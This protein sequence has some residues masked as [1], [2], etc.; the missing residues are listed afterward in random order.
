[1]W[2]KSHT[3]SQIRYITDTALLAKR[4]SATDTALLA[5]RH[6][7]TIKTNTRPH[8]NTIAYVIGG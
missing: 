2:E 7:A 5:K 3:E 6:S 4:H 1:M 8:P